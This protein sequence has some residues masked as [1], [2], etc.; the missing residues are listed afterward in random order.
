METIKENPA[1]APAA[2]GSVTATWPDA[3]GSSPWSRDAIAALFELPM[4]DLMFRAQSVHREHFDA[5]QVQVSSLKSIKTGACPEDCKYCPQSAHYDTG[6]KREALVPLDEVMT[7]ARQAK[8]AGATRF[9]MAAAWRGPHA[10]D[11][12][13]VKEMIGAV[14]DLGLET[15]ASL[16]LLDDGQAVEL[17][18]AGLDYYNHNIDTSEE[19]YGEIITTRSFDDRRQTLAQVRNAGI[20]VCCGGIVGLGESRND[21]VSML[22]ALATMAPPPESVPINQLIPI[23][24]TP[25][26]AERTPDPFEFVRTIAVARIVMPKAMVRLSAGR[27]QMSD[28][29][30]ALCFLAGANSL[31]LGEILLTAKNPAP[32]LDHELF[33]RLGIEP[34]ASNEK[35]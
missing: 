29:L 2:T 5:N 22:Q 14:K 28:E 23:P 16:G 19:Y 24:G 12:P 31:F 1:S 10:R 17:K 35:S 8:A 15:C 27:E 20:N 34:M 9:C 6:L 13:A 25:L 26:A 3:R 18:A 11:L 33:I 30:Q 21:R 4:A 32:D 7:A